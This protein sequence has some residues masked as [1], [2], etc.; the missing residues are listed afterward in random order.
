MKLGD[1]VIREEKQFTVVGMF[2]I[3]TVLKDGTDVT[4]P[5]AYLWIEL[6]GLLIPTNMTKY[7]RVAARI[8]GAIVFAGVQFPIKYG[9]YAEN[10]VDNYVISYQG[11]EYRFEIGKQEDLVAVVLK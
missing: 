6:D 8:P 5:D 2:G 11:T 10:K 9:P 1:C 4:K 3:L 7:S